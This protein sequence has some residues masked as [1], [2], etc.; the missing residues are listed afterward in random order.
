IHLAIILDEHGGVDGLV[1]LEDLIEEIVGDIFD[2]SDVAERDI[3]VQENGDAV[4]EGGGVVGRINNRLG[5]DLPGRGYKTVAG[6]F[7]DFARTA[8]KTGGQYS[9]R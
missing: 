2:E 8:S 5:G 1:T 6:V 7:F 3:V 4:V 9:H